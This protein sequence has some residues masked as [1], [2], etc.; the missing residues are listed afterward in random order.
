[1]GEHISGGHFGLYSLTVQC[2][3][4]HMITQQSDNSEDA[5]LSLFDPS[6]WISPHEDKL[7]AS[8]GV[9]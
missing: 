8:E 2:L 9:S 7:G 5:T 4:G 1:M 6:Y 3:L